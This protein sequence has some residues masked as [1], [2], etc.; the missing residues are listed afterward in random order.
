MCKVQRDSVTTYF[1]LI[2]YSQYSELGC[3]VLN[4]CIAVGLST[5]EFANCSSVHRFTCCERGLNR[6]R[7]S[8]I[9]SS[10]TPFF[11]ATVRPAVETEAAGVAFILN[12]GWTKKRGHRLMTIILSIL[13]RFK[14]FF[15]GRFLGKFAVKWISKSHRILHIIL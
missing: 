5:S 6:L 3:L 10:G 13:N 8:L 15:T 14:K 7:I 4:T 12:T 2:G 1:V 9:E 11:A